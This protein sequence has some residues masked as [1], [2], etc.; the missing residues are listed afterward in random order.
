MKIYKFTE[1]DC[2]FKSI[3]LEGSKLLEK[4][5]DNL[6]NGGSPFHED[7][8][9]FAWV[10]DQPD[11]IN[12]CDFPFISGYIPVIS[13]RALTIL[14][15]F[16]D[17]SNI[18]VLPIKV[19]GEKYYLLHIMHSSPCL[20]IK[21]SAISYFMNGGIKQI[22]DYVF[23]PSVEKEQFFF[24]VDQLHTHVFV[25]EEVASIIEKEHLIGAKFEECKIKDLSFF[26]KLFT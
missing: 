22:K 6:F 1:S 15:P 5:D 16:I 24:M 9:H 26:D 20:N 2:N 4:L 7:F 13:E 10:S 12:N 3:N 21:A 25:R 14:K 17:K 11:A 18:E 19:E 23:L 8:G